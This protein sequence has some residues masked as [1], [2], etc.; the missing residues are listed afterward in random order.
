MVKSSVRRDILEELDTGI[1]DGARLLE[2]KFLGGL[3]LSPKCIFSHVIRI[4]VELD[5]E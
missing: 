2:S 1:Q 4:D 3:I 5:T